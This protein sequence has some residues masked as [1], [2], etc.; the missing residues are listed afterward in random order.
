VLN[1]IEAQEPPPLASRRP[2]ILPELA[3]VVHRSLAKDPA[4]RPADARALARELAPFAGERPHRQDDPLD[5][6]LSD[7]NVEVVRATTWRTRLAALG[8]RR[9]AAI[10]LVACALL[11]VAVAGTRGAKETPVAAEPTLAATAP[12]PAPTTSAA[13]SAP[14]ALPVATI[15]AADDG[16]APRS[17]TRSTP[18]GQAIVDRTPSPRHATPPPPRRGTKPPSRPTPPKTPA[19]GS[20]DDD[21]IE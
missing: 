1:Q 7:D 10:T 20:E 21:R 15:A 12:A 11:G 8:T 14:A 2:D 17:A 16:E 19:R 9:I 3:A 6:S 4:R 13:P 5:L 18:G